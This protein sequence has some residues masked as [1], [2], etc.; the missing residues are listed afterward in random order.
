MFPATC[1][2]R[3]LVGKNTLFAKKAFAINDFV[4]RE[5]IEPPTISLRDKS[6][7]V[8]SKKILFYKLKLDLLGQNSVF[9]ATC[10]PAQQKKK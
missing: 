9:I 5:G 10:F 7:G 1:F 4:P 3:K 6:Q 2:H 8:L